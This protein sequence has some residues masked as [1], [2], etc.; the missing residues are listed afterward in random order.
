MNNLP[1]KILI[2]FAAGF[3]G[4]FNP[5]LINRAEGVSVETFHE[6]FRLNTGKEWIDA[7]TEE[8]RS[9]VRDYYHQKEETIREGRERLYYGSDE[10]GS[11]VP[12]MIEST[13][14]VRRRFELKRKKVW[15][16][17]TSEE[18]EVFLKEYKK[19]KEKERKLQK[20]R[21]EKIAREE[22][23]ERQRKEKERKRLERLKVQKER[24]ALKEA[25][26]REKEREES[27]EKLDDALE[28]LK[29]RMRDA[30]KNR[31]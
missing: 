29:K 31:R 10:G 17:A 5:I 9:F 19:E 30:Q 26:R 15:E 6:K 25:R 23:K 21:E 27:R 20:R 1:F 13:L 16:E 7:T 2:I 11:Q 3:L 12:H 8:K 18:Q 4:M 28:R 24:E 14:D 22:Q